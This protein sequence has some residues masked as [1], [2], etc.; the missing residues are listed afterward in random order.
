[1]RCFPS[2]ANSVLELCC[3]HC[4]LAVGV[5]RE[6]WMPPTAVLHRGARR[7]MVDRIQWNAETIIAA[8]EREPSVP[9]MCRTEAGGV[10]PSVNL[11]T[12]N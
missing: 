8:L 7:A 12:M 3:T 6:E 4:S 10:L 1:M 5:R 9:Q 11:L 2:S